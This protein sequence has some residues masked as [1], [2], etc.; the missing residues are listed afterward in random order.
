MKIFNCDETGWSGK[1]KAK[2]KV[3]TGK[4]KHT[5]S[6]KVMGGGGNHITAH[7]CVCADGRFL[8]TRIIFKV[9]LYSVQ[10]Q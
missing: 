5:I 4:R 9:I 1:E 7:L 2:E 8:P 6:R 3:A 10:M